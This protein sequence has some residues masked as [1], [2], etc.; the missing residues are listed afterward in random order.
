MEDVANNEFL[1]FGKKI[2]VL[3]I[4]SQLEIYEL[5]DKIDISASSIAE[6]ERCS[7]F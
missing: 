3:D 4:F 1:E 6:A 2:S 5:E 7:M